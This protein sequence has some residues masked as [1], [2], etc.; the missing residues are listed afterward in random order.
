MFSNEQEQSE[1]FGKQSSVSQLRK[2]E[3]DHPTGNILQSK[4]PVLA[5]LLEASL[6]SWMSGNETELKSVWPFAGIALRM[7]LLSYF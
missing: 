3:S 4:E 7:A 6:N 2:M 5:C 1:V